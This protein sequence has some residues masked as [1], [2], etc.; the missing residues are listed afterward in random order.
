VS[1]KGKR[2]AL[3]L[4]VAA[5]A[6]AA[7]CMPPNRTEF[8]EKLA[9]ENRKVARSAHAFRSSFIGLASGSSADSAAVHAAY[10]DLQKTLNEA[11]AD[12]KRQMLPPNSEHAKDFLAAYRDYLSSEQDILKGPMHDI[13]DIVDDGSLSND[14]KLDRIKAKMQEV[15]SAEGDQSN[16]QTPLGKLLQAQ[17]QYCNDHNFQAL[18]LAAYVASSKNGK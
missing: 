15:V 8:I 10:A 9:L 5:A 6:L 11:Q 1:Q 16:T 3:W 4:A 12:M 17:S 7:G 13:V 18:G 14:D 2:R